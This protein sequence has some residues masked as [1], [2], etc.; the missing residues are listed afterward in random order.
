MSA[1]CIS[2]IAGAVGRGLAAGLVGTVAITASQMIEMKITGREP[3]MAPADAVCKV[4]GVQPDG[5]AEKAR[6]A[7]MMHWDYGTNW[8]VFRG[9]LGAF[10]I[11]GPLATLLHFLAVSAAAAIM[12][13]A[14]ELAP[15]IREQEPKQIGIE[16]VHHFVYAL[17]AGAFYDMLD[18]AGDE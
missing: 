10:G 17:A 3:S 6:L 1:K 5:E 8:G 2:R 14:L 7:Q 4:L 9:L 13:P 15:P 12:L 11:K 16:S 18:D